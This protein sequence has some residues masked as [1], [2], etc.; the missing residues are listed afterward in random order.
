MARK[1][2]EGLSLALGMLL[3][4]WILIGLVK[5]LTG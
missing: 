4:A 2:Y 3:A 5:L 1:G